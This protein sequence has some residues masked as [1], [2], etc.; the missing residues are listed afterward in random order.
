MTKAGKNGNNGMQKSQLGSSV[1]KLRPELPPVPETEQ[2]NVPQIK[3]EMKDGQAYMNIVAQKDES[4]V[5]ADFM[6]ALAFPN[7]A[8]FNGYFS[9]VAGYALENGKL[10]EDRVNFIAQFVASMKPKD[11]AETL[12]LTQMAAVQYL[13]MMFASRLGRVSA[14]RSCDFYDRTVNKL[15]RTSTTQ[16]VTLKQYRSSGKQQ[17][18]V[19]HQHV[20]VNDHAQAI[21]GDV[22]Q[23]G[24]GV[25][26]NPEP[27]S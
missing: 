3:Y 23:G 21:I 19:K 9:I 6:N 17:I 14:L 8:L 1:V 18:T 7:R 26:K 16:M 13:A 20:N 27:T 15:M 24:G 22:T 2:G 5:L 11:P 4:A 12:L 10:D 25:S